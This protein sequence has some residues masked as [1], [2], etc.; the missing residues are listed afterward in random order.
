VATSEFR[1]HLTPRIDPGDRVWPGIVQPRGAAVVSTSTS[2]SASIGQLAGV[3]NS[4]SMVSVTGVVP[5]DS[6]ET[7]N[8][9]LMFAA[10]APIATGFLIAW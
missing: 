4:V 2:A 3:G 7:E 9:K 5:S 1:R 10:A 6:L 8:W